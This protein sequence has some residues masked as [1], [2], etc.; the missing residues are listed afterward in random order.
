MTLRSEPRPVDVLGNPLIRQLV[1][2]DLEPDDF[3]IFGSGPL[4]AYG[5]RESIQDLD[6]VARGTAW[7]RA[8]EIGELTVGAIS[9]APIMQYKDIHFSRDWISEF[10]DTDDLIERAELVQGLRFA[11]LA[12]VLAYKRML[13]R[14][15]D[16]VDI[17][18]TL[19][20]L[21]PPDVGS[22]RFPIVRVSHRGGALG[23]PRPMTCCA[24]QGRRN[25]VASHE[26]R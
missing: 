21:R 1:A 14:R 22:D 9:G 23:M 5:L 3:V 19:A 10:W 15:K 8:R 13:M 17:R 7:R 16:V 4:L 11:R 12:D 26:G 24:V 6:V 20:R 2:L 18:R 25:M